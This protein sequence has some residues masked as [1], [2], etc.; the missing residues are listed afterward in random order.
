MSN[1][2][3]DQLIDVNTIIR[4]NI[5]IDDS[6]IDGEKVMMDIERGQYYMLNDVASRIW[7]IIEDDICIK[8][9]INLL[10]KEYD[11][12]EETCTKSVLEFLNKLNIDNLIE[13]M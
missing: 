6:E 5:N 2:N 13:I 3:C 11:I 4:K 1:K 7:T 12:N 9:V 10:L 8:D